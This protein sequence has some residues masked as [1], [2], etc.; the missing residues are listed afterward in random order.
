[1]SNKERPRPTFWEFIPY[2]YGRRT[3]GKRPL[4][5]KYRDWVREDNAGPG[6]TRRVVTRFMIP[7]VLLMSP[8]LLTARSVGWGTAIIVTLP[9]ILGAL[10]FCFVFDKYYRRATLRR[11]GFDEALADETVRQKDA[12]AHLEYE[13]R[14]GRA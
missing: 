4:P 5:E 9:I 2:A 1:M 13:K 12:A 7:V 14:H 6:A 10:Y 3:Y 8:F 11:H